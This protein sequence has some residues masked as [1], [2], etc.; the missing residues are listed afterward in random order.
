MKFS[1]PFNNI[2]K[3]GFFIVL[4]VASDSP[5]A[6]ESDQ[7]NQNLNSQASAQRRSRPERRVRGVYKARITPHWF[8]HR[9][10][11][12]AENTC[13]WYRNNLSGDMKEFILVDAEKGIRQKA[14]DHVKLAEA[15]SKVTDEKY[16]AD[17][18]P[19]NYI[20]FIDNGK[21]ILFNTAEKTLKCNLST[22][23]VILSED[24]LT[25][26]EESNEP[27]F[28]WRDQR[29]WRPGRFS[30]DQEHPIASPNGM[31]NVY[32]KDN[33]I[34]VRQGEDGE[35][36]QLSSDGEEGNSYIRVEWA[37]DS[38]SIIAWRREPGD[39][40]EVYLIQSSP[41]ERWSSRAAFT[42]LRPAG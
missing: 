24:T 9:T 37:P 31:W 1:V 16:K 20:K 29:G 18:L 32:I 26:P 35:E 14:F 2:I 13:F 12:G 19:F 17:Q 25:Q 10:P 40:K 3:V 5:T 23:D 7:L 21:A 34:Y 28:G 42:S 6:L 38:Q 30:N 4:L 22:Y 39:C 36:I 27:R 41:P 15:L 8:F 11:D 33:N